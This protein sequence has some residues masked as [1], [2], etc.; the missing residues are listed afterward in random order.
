MP[1]KSLQKGPREAG[2]NLVNK[3]SASRGRWAER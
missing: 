2:T 3:I 1:N